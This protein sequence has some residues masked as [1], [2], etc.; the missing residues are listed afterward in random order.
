V[1]EYYAQLGDKEQLRFVLDEDAVIPV[2]DEEWFEDDIVAQFR[3][4]V[5]VVW[6]KENLQRNLEYMER[7]LGKPLRNYFYRD[8]YNDHIKTI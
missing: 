5:R 4:F 3:R 6:G 1:Q 8:F 7:V 2:L